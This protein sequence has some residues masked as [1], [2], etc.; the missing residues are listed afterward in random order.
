MTT[1]VTVL[2][3]WIGYLPELLAGL[4]LSVTL[5][6]VSMGLGLVCGFLTAVARGSRIRLI[7]APFDL[8]VSFFR[9]TP[10]LVQIFLAYYGLPQFGITL[11]PVPSAVI[12][13]TLNSPTLSISFL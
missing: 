12:V 2:E 4:R 13:F 9:G 7:R 11:Q 6:L 1:L 8:Y 10:L 3:R 5:T